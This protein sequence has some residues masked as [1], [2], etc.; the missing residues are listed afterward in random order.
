VHRFTRDQKATNDTLE[1]L[2]AALS[3]LGETATG[4]EK[5]EPED[6]DYWDDDEA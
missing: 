1:V 2:E 5:D 3:Q 4:E 6:W